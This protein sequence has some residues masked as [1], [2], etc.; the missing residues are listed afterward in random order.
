MNKLFYEKKISDLYKGDNR[1]L[2]EFY[3]ELNIELF[4]KEKER[5]L[6]LSKQEV[7][8]ALN[9]RISLKDRKRLKQLEEELE[10]QE[11]SEGNSSL[12]EFIVSVFANLMIPITDIYICEFLAL[13]KIA[14]KQ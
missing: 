13:Y 14:K 7:S 5:L 12:P 10:N 4:E 2:T 1:L 6:L 3:K 8:R 11:E 9:E